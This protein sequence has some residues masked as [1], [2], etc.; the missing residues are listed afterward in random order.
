MRLSLCI[1]AV[2]LGC[3]LLPAQEL[4]R[5]SYNLRIEEPRDGESSLQMTLV[6]ASGTVMYQLKREMPYDT[7]RPLVHLFA[8]GSVMLVD[9]FAGV[10]ERYGENGRMTDR[11]ALNGRVSP[12][13]ERIGFLKGNDSMAV[14]FVSEPE[15]PESRLLIVDRLGSTIVNKPVSGSFASGMELSP[16]GTLIAVGTYNWNGPSLGHKTEFLNTQGAVISSLNH[17]FKGGAWGA[18]DSLFLVYG[19]NDA[20]I[21]DARTGIVRSAFDLGSNTVVHAALWD[22]GTPLVAVSPPPRFEMG[23]WIFSQLVVLNAADASTVYQSQSGSF[24]K[25]EFEKSDSGVFLRVDRQ[26][27]P[28][29]PASKRN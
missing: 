25:L 2:F 12:N 21:V 17:E 8:D 14:L 13:H 3:S 23:A 24:K 26:Q 16:D 4:S 7:P 1:L 6:G 9:A 5:G 29:D 11:I 28:L 22:N 20:A 10:Y 27:I 18:G 19:R 15:K